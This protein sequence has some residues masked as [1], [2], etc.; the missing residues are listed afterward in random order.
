M[1]PITTSF[2]TFVTR[3]PSLAEVMYRGASSDE[4][5]KE[6]VDVQTWSKEKFK[7]ND[8]IVTHS[9]AGLGPMYKRHETGTIFMDTPSPG[10]TKETV[11]TKFG[12]GVEFSEDLLDDGM[13][14]IVEE[15]VE[16]LGRTYN[17]T[18]N[19]QVG[20]LLDDAFTGTYY[21][22]PDGQPILSDNHTTYAGGPAIKNAP[23][24]AVQFSYQGVQDIMTLMRRQTDDRGNP[25]PALKGGQSVQVII[26]PEM[27]FIADTLFNAGAAL[28]PT[29]NNN[30]VNVLRSNRFRVTVNPYMTSTT[31]FFIVNPDDKGIWLVDRKPL[32]RSFRENETTKSVTYDARGRWALHVKDWR[33]FYGSN[34]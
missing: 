9:L 3:D 20:Q 16:D 27:E 34:G 32:D 5:Y 1:P 4:I 6:C 15:V 26:P 14:S 17:L 23:T 10:A 25:R 2:D 29:S 13:Y 12:L 28:D 31:G 18:R 21:T 7:Y 30:T 11:Y 22:G 8:R 24:N 19:I 33:G